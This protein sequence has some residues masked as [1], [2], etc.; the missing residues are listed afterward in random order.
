MLWWEW[1]QVMN[2]L[3]GANKFKSPLR[4]PS[5]ADRDVNKIGLCG[6]FHRQFGS[7]G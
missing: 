1:G 7:K 2:S 3:G 4:Q 6:W 5:E